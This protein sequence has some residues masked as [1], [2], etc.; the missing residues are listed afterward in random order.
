MAQPS[1]IQL[2]KSIVPWVVLAVKLGAS[3]LIRSAWFF[4]SF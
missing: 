2:W 3:E 1:P 4:V